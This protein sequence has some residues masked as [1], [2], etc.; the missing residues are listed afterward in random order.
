MADDTITTD[1]LPARDL[2][3]LEDRLREHLERSEAQ[4]VE[5][6]SVLTDMVRSNDTIQEDQ[7]SARLMV[8]AVRD[9]V[10]HIRGALNR[11][12]NG[13]YGL[14]ATCGTLIPLER[15]EAIPTVAHCARCA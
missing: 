6:E 1:A 10:R 7:N 14:C 2:A 13:T 5:L 8:D 9:D 3:R 15:L 4:L 12:A 11:I